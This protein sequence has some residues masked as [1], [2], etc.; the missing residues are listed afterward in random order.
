MVGV[1]EK[2]N[3]TNIFIS[4]EWENTLL[5]NIVEY[6]RSTNFVTKDTAIL[7]LS[8]EYSGMFGQYLSHKLSSFNEP[9]SIEPVNIP[10]GSEFKVQVHPDQLDPYSK[11]IVVDSGCMSGNNFK[12]IKN[13]LVNYGILE[14]NIFITS[15]CC[16]NRSIIK[17]NYCP[18]I[19]D[20][21]TQMPHFWWECKTDKFKNK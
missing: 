8:C 18:L 20:G 9:I 17:P 21:D 19:Y 3:K 14:S 4:R 12:N 16:D 7:Q 2:M 13:I 1:K 6:I 10:Y 15:I 11:F 5:D